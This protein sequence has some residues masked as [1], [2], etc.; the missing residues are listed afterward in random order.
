[1]IKQPFIKP[2]DMPVPQLSLY[3]ALTMRADYLRSLKVLQK[4]TYEEHKY[5]ILGIE[6]DRLEYDINL[7]QSL[8]L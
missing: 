4:Q 8:Q 3:D 2:S 6:I 5:E 1:M 7:L